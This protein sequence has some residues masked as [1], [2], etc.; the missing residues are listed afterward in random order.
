MATK[1]FAANFEIASEKS[2]SAFLRC[3]NY[4]FII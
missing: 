2:D 1:K 4:N 3:D